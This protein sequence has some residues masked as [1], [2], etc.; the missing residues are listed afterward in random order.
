MEQR[1]AVPGRLHTLVDATRATLANPED[2]AQVF[3][4]AEV[5]SFG[6]PERVL[7]RMRREPTGAR[8][9]AGRD[10][11]LGVLRDRRAL[12]AMPAGSLARAYL[13]FLDREGISADGLVEASQEGMSPRHH[14]NHDDLA[15]MRMRLRDSHDLWHAVTGYH[16]DLLG[17][18]SLLAFTFAQTRHPG[19]GFLAG[20]GWLLGMHAGARN[21]IAGGFRRGRRAAW[22]PAQDWIALLPRPL[23][24]VRREL[25]VDA[26]PDYEPVR[27]PPPWLRRAT[28]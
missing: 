17:E 2:T 13:A 23:D 21:M 26:A 28:A 22:L 3:R 24:D 25:G 11:L 27:E 1:T 6:A 9:L 15:W 5:L 8:L 10:D 12:E 14:G 20:L 4:I 7:R 19:I 16:G 18:A